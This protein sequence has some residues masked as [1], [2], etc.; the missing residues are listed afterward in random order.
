MKKPPK[1]TELYPQGTDEG[2]EEQRFFIS[3][4]RD[5]YIFKSISQLSL[6]THLTKERIEQ[7]IS[8]YASLNVLVQNPKNEDQWAYWEKCQ[9]QLPPKPVSL[10]EMDKKKRISQIKEGK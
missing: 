6:E 7:I 4:I 3:L 10:S 2:D 1:W 8:K 5:K 9:D